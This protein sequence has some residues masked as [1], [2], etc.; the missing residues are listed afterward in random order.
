MH[1]STADYETILKD[2]IPLFCLPRDFGGSQ[3]SIEEMHET[4]CKEFLRL[5][6]YFIEEEK[7]WSTKSGVNEQPRHQF[8]GLEID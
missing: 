3:P 5:K 2:I 1:P 7:Q 4:H 6:Q 8:S